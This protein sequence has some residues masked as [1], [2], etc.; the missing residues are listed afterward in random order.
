MYIYMCIYIYIYTHT[1][2][3]FSCYPFS[4]TR[5]GATENMCAHGGRIS[6]G[7]GV[8]V[9]KTGRT[10]ISQGGPTIISTTYISEFHLK[11]TE[12]L[13]VSSEIQIMQLN[14]RCCL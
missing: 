12:Q 2:V 7:P 1:R 3:S 4:L 5:F 11:Q 9:M 6:Y 14:K 8:L 10:E 13:H